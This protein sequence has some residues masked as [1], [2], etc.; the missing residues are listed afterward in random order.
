MAERGGPCWRLAR[1]RASYL[2][3]STVAANSRPI[4][5][6][7][8]AAGF[9][10]GEA[11]RLLHHPLDRALIDESVECVGESTV[12]Q[13]RSGGRLKILERNTGGPVL[14]GQAFEDFQHGHTLK[15]I[16]S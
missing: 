3:G 15:G 7:A 13:A 14:G 12:V 2:A 10:D 16:G 11:S 6:E 5:V 1:G 9:G 4:L 8:L